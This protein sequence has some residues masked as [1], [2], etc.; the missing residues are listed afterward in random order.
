MSDV[1]F[2]TD[3]EIQE[4]EEAPAPAPA[5]APKKKTKNP[6]GLSEAELEIKQANI[7]AGRRAGGATRNKKFTDTQKKAELFD[8]YLKDELSYEATLL[9]GFKPVRNFNTGIKEKIVEKII[10]VDS[11]GNIVEPKKTYTSNDFQSWFD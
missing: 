4:I 10:L 1:E 3:A 2:D 8:L 5:P 6:R 7:N 9:A 11:N